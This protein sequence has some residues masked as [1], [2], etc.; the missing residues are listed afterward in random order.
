VLAPGELAV[1]HFAALA[2]GETSIDFLSAVVMDIDRVEIQ[3]L[4]SMGGHV[5]V[6][7]GVGVGSEETWGRGWSLGSPYPNPSRGS[8]RAWLARPAGVGA[9]LYRLAVYDAR[10][11]LVR[12]LEVPPAGSLAEVAWDGRSDGAIEAPSGVYF[13][14][15]ETPREVIR[16]KITLVR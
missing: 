4:G 5:T 7:P 2:E 11:R 15:L 14:R 8:A 16:R 12:S 9:D 10:G 6:S 13:L 1:I 3:P